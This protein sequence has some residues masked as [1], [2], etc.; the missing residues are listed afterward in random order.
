MEKNKI[1][2]RLYVGGLGHTIS[3]TELKE[4]FN[5]FGDVTDVEIISRKDEQGNKTK[6]FAYLNINISETDLKKCMSILNKTKWRGGTLQ[7]ELA[8]ESFLHRLVQERQEVK[9]KKEK[10]LTDS[11]SSLM[12]SL[13]KA[14]VVDFQLKAVP[15]TEVPDHKDWVVS[16]FGRVLPVLNLKGQHRRKFI[17][18]DPS[19]YCHNINKLF[20][21]SSDTIPISQLTWQ[22]EAGN[23]DISK[24]RR[25]E[26]TSPKMQPKKL[27]IQSHQ[28]NEHSS[29]SLSSVSHFKS[30]R[31]NEQRGKMI[32]RPKIKLDIPSES[33]HIHTQQS[34]KLKKK[35]FPNNYPSFRNSMSDS[36]IDSEE[37]V[38]AMVEMEKRMQKGILNS[39][40]EDSNL[41]V[42]GDT[43][44]LK[45][46]THWALTDPAKTK[47]VSQRQKATVKEGI[48][49]DNEYDSA[50][51]DEIIAMKKTPN[52]NSQ[53]NECPQKPKLGKKEKHQTEASKSMNNNDS[54]ITPLGAT[55]NEIQN[56]DLRSSGPNKRDENKMR[57]L[58]DTA[59]DD[60]SESSSSGTDLED[61]GSNSESDDDDYETMMQNCYHLDLSLND[62][63]R[64]ATEST[65]EESREGI[66]SSEKLCDSSRKVKKMKNGGTVAE[67][68]AMNKMPTKPEDILSSILEEE[69]T[70]DEHKPKKREPC[71]KFPAFKGLGSL[72]EKKSSE[73]S[74]NADPV[75]LSSSDSWRREVVSDSCL[76]STTHKLCFHEDN[77]LNNIQ[78][79]SRKVLKIPSTISSGL[80]KLKPGT[81]SSEDDNAV[82]RLAAG[83]EI[84][85][86]RLITKGAKS[87]IRN[88][89]SSTKSGM[90]EETSS[91]TS[92]DSSTEDQSDG[93][94]RS[95][96]SAKESSNTHSLVPVISYQITKP[97]SRSFPLSA[98]PSSVDSL[99]KKMESPIPDHSKQVLD[100]QKRLAA[101]QERQRERDKQ[102][103]LI[104]GALSNLDC[105]STSKSS[106]IVFESDSEMEDKMEEKSSGG[107][108]SRET[109]ETKEFAT[110]RSGKLFDDSEDEDDASDAD[111][112]KRFRIKTQFEGKAGEKLLHLQSRFGTDDRFRMDSR[113]LESGSE[114]NDAEERKDDITTE[115]EQLAAEKKKNLEILQSLMHVK[116]TT[117]AKKFKDIN[118]L[119]YD[120]TNE[121]H[122][123]FETKVETTLKESKAKRKKKREEAEKLPEVSK[124][125]YHSIAINFKEVFGSAKRMSEESDMIMPWDKADNHPDGTDV[126]LTAEHSLQLLT[127]SDKTEGTSAFTFSFFGDDTGEPAP[128]EELYKIETMKPAKVAWQE[129][130]FKDSS[131]EDD[132]EMETADN[133]EAST[134]TLP[135]PEK[136]TTRFFFFFR[137]DERLK[138]GPKLFYRSSN[139]DDE[140]EAWEERSA[141]LLEECRKRHKDAK[142]KLKA[143]Q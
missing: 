13:R 56:I 128:K 8:K 117:K 14:G 82:L 116:Q 79:V 19:K 131:S 111:D 129:D 118:A 98:A 64:L 31:Q 135:L 138:V 32:Q 55:P 5:K 49:D 80:E 67:K 130:H 52:Q 90:E 132:D 66:T 34:N 107:L 105:E 72:L 86:F 37:E 87:N 36:E 58:P 140:R 93:T 68:S 102:K 50:D 88:D 104:Q 73:A 16:K 42:V 61:K 89:E 97:E 114:D 101:V 9:E 4:R 21:E 120:P 40:D 99:Q 23:D 96:S 115:E 110:K 44:E 127:E 142:R 15:G 92:S 59:I 20:C 10:P 119:R 57:S 63:E 76:E 122:A 106:H 69:S 139:L 125:I 108:V 94:S 134:G 83:K 143:K 7:I 43:F 85:S 112:V 12:E 74:M 70:D 3:Q 60:E 35:P 22:L 133:E 46:K 65:N 27:R 51:T 137:D 54:V 29:G 103:Q 53:K 38:K 78:S 48:D 1:L 28:E 62:L 84:K 33:L 71:M 6:T 45:Y 75:C 39:A 30:K 141:L 11:R 124:E 100:N 2:K 95:K 136:N 77:G 121:D 26:F 91:T 41:E 123:A 126:S 81:S 24:K 113:F 47:S 17:K 18:Y 109:S 25:G